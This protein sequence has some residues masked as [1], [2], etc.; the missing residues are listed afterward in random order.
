MTRHVNPESGVPM[1]E[2]LFP[3]DFSADDEKIEGSG[4]SLG[5]WGHGSRARLLALLHLEPAQGVRGQVLHCY[6]CG[7]GKGVGKHLRAI[8]TR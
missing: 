7:Q 3:K 6:T 1:F 4:L 5:F 8:F 2:Y